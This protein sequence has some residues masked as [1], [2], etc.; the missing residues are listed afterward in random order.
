MAGRTVVV[1]ID[2]SSSAMRAAR[3]AAAEAH[4][5]SASLHLLHCDVK[6]L[7]VV[8]DIPVVPPHDVFLENVRD[9]AEASLRQAKDDVLA[10]VPGVVVETEFRMGAPATALIDFSRHAEMIVLGSRG[11][12][13]YTGLLIGSVAVAVSGHASCPVAVVRGEH[14]AVGTEAIVVGVDGSSY[15]AA[16]LAYAFEVAAAREVPLRAVHAWHSLVRDEAWAPRPTDGGRALLQADEERLLTE[17]LAGWCEKYPDVV[18]QQFAPLDKPVR[19]LLSHAERAQLVVVGA[20]GRG[21]FLG[22]L[23]GSTSQHLIQHSPCPVVIA[24]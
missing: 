4:R 5:R 20:R 3:W 17:T 16:T 1:G 14:E 18:V 2:G 8:P 6:S 11:L 19:A 22:L 12:G 9:H 10:A 13:G 24:R 21:G 7:V 15:S 23:L